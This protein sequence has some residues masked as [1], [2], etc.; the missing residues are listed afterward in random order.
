MANQTQAQF[1]GGS[2][3]VISAPTGGTG[4]QWYKDGVAIT[5][6]NT[7]SYTVTT[8]GQY[9]ATFTNVSGCAVQTTG[10]YFTQ[11]CGTSTNVVL[12][13]TATS[14]TGGYQWYSSSDGSSFSA[15]SGATG[16]SYTAT[17]GGFYKI[18]ITGTGSLSCTISSDPF[19]V[20]LLDCPCSVSSVGGSLTY[21]GGVICSSTNSG[22]ISLTGQTGSVVKWQTSVNGGGTWTDVGSSSG[23]T[24]YTFVNA[25]NNQLFRA[26]VNNGSGC[27]D[28]NSTPVSLTV[29]NLNNTTPTLSANSFTNTCPVTTVDL[30]NVI[31]TNTTAGLTLTWHSNTP[32]TAINR[33]SS[34]TALSAGTYYAAFL[35]PISS[36]YSG[37]AVANATVQS[38][39][40]TASGTI[41]CSKTQIMP[42]PIAGV[43]SQHD[44]M[45]TIN[46]T[47]PGNFP[48]TLSGSGMSLANGILFIQATTTGTQTFHIPIKYDGSTLGVLNYTLGSAGSCTA[49]LT[50]SFKKAL[51][52]IWTLECIP[53]EGPS[54]R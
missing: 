53:T 28:A 35:D 47:Q 4:Y 12:S 1:S 36:C 18:E 6:A 38:V 26:V 20:Y 5:G 50:K 15:I 17:A 34:V 30:S 44:L 29:S 54:L 22:I 2:S 24:S 27:S 46:V 32:A 8:T 52:D 11:N 33:L 43:I 25:Q 45:I 14:G 40:C 23:I 19:L 31:A 3:K 48:I 49:D 37:S 10:S 41:D 9:Y 42:A 7:Y 21:I 13:N 51:C 39:P 16:S